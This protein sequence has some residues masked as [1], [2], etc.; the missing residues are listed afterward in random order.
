[1]PFSNATTLTLNSLCLIWFQP[2]FL[3]LFL[4]LLVV[5]DY[6]SIVEIE[7]CDLENG[8]GCWTCDA[9]TGMF[10]LYEFLVLRL[11][12]WYFLLECLIDSKGNFLLGNFVWIFWIWSGVCRLWLIW[13]LRSAQHCYVDALVFCLNWTYFPIW[14]GLFITIIT[15]F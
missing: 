4:F 9:R 7:S 10:F 6:I 13:S 12:F 5:L 14:C 3:F 15:Y 2:S 1:M 11:Q 8:G